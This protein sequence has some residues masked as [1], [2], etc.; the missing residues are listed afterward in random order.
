MIATIRGEITFI[1]GDSMVI[2]SNNMG[3]RVFVPAQIRLQK[4][5][6]DRIFLFT[7]LVVREELLALYGFET[8][9]QC[10]YFGLFLTVSGIGPKTA[11]SILSTLSVDTIRKAILGNQPEILGQVPGIGKKSA[12]KIMLFLQGKIKPEGL[13]EG[14]GGSPS[15]EGEVL[16]A[17]TNLGYSII[18]AQAALQHIPADTPPE[19]EA[20]IT[21]A[22][23]FLGR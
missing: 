20:L 23:R 19:V 15:H 12:P 16:Q 14:E 9:E 5:T 1:D 3:F 2:E 13:V 10:D 4:K 22:L 11:L 7:H 8:R 21:A 18:E 6:G 17:L